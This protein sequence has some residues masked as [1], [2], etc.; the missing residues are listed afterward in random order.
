MSSTPV[1]AAMEYAWNVVRPRAQEIDQSESALREAFEGLFALHAMAVRRPSRFGTPEASEQEFRDLQEMLARCSGT[2]AFLT[3][4]HQSA[5]G[6]IA[7][8]PNEALSERLLAGMSGGE[9]RMGVGFSQLRRTG[10]PIMRATP[11]GDDGYVLSGTVPWITG[12]SF[13]RQF[14]VGAT[15]DDGRSLLGVM[16]FASIEGVVELSAPMRLAA[17]EPARTVSARINGYRM[18]AEDVVNIVPGDWLTRNDKINAA[19]HGYFSLGCARAGLDIVEERLAA[20]SLSHLKEIWDRLD[21]E[22]LACRDQMLEVQAASSFEEKVRVRAWAIDLAVRC[23]HA[24]VTASSGAA[25]SLGHPAQRVFR[26]SIVF[27]VSAQTE[28]VM[29][30]TLRRI[31]GRGAQ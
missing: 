12:E 11:D 30:E 28:H 17:M 10:P 2:L 26:E 15:L 4:Q 29:T 6:M 16:P 27:T 7:K 14:V 8:S 18:P 31:A 20:R 23:A 1:Q 21:A 24:A 13:Y 3:T 9:I 25:N 19:L 5:V 22:L